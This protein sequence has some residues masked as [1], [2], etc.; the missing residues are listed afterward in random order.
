M[1][2]IMKRIQDKKKDIN[3]IENKYYFN[4]KMS[5]NSSANP[6]QNNTT[7]KFTVSK[8]SN[9]SPNTSNQPLYKAHVKP[10]VK[11]RNDFNANS[12]IKVTP[13]PPKIMN[14]RHNMV[15]NKHV[16][17]GKRVN[18][19]VSGIAQKKL[20]A[21]QY[22]QVV[23]EPKKSHRYLNSWEQGG[24]IED[25]DDIQEEFVS[26]NSDYHRK[27]PYDEG[28]AA[29]F[30]LESMSRVNGYDIESEDEDI[31]EDNDN[32]Y[33]SSQFGVFRGVSNERNRMKSATRP[34][35]PPFTQFREK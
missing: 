21:K 20:R 31:S 35:S 8:S 19:Q 17:K 1:K 30:L 22:Q 13:P 18:K 15:N 11:S 14:K 9:V 33:S 28:S 32:G 12:I 25:E 29:T 27:T 4:D 7:S 5:Q 23:N 3:R 10:Q 26:D 24:V 34:Y 16:D 6:S 2:D